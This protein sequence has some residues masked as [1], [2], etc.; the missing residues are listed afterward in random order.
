MVRGLKIWINIENGLSYLCSENKDTDQLRC[1]YLAADVRLCFRKCIKASFHM[2]RLKCWA[3][4]STILYRHCTCVNLYVA[5][6]NSISALR[7]R[8]LRHNTNNSAIFMKLLQHIR[9]LDSLVFVMVCQGESNVHPQMMV[10]RMK[11]NYN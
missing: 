8:R 11:L 10:L 4:F 7:E 1:G 5:I 6:T 2:T 3:T 9:Q